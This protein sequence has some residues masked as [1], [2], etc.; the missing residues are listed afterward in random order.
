[1]QGELNTRRHE[2]EI[3]NR[4]R[5][6]VRRKWT[7]LRRANDEKP[8]DVWLDGFGVHVGHVNQRYKPTLVADV[9][10]TLPF[11]YFEHR[12]GFSDEE[13][14]SIGVRPV[15]ESEFYDTPDPIRSPQDAVVKA[16]NET[17]FHVPL[18]WSHGSHGARLRVLETEAEAERIKTRLEGR[19]DCC[20][21]G[22]ANHGVEGLTVQEFDE[23][24]DWLSPDSWYEVV[25]NFGETDA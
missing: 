18:V 23:F 17:G 25:V 16:L 15:S 6:M 14:Y 3:E 10:R 24:R 7:P 4:L 9:A 12:L 20:Y 11:G 19:I 2:D 1:M 13:G 8:M 22:R 5:E 21:E